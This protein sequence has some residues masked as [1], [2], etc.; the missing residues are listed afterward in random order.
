MVRKTFAAL[1]VLGLMIMIPVTSRSADT[2]NVG[3]LAVG[4]SIWW[5]GGYVTT[6]PM[7][8]APFGVSNQ[9]LD[10]CSIQGHPCFRYDL[11]TAS[12]GARLRIGF[13][14]PMRDDGFEITVRDAAGGVIG[15][16]TN[17]NKYSVELFVLNPPAATY[18][19]TVA[20]YSADYAHFRMRAKLE[21]TI[22][23]LGGTGDALPNL[24]VTRLWEFTFAA[25]LNPAN[26]LFPPD[27]VNP[28]MEAGGVRPMS[29]ALDEQL[30]YDGP[31][32]KRCLR[33][34]F[35]LANIGV[36]NFDVRFTGDQSGAPA[37]MLQCVQQRGGGTPRA[38]PAGTGSWHAT[39]GHYHYDDIIHHTI[40]RVTDRT[41]GAMEE[42]GTGLKIGYSPADQG[43]PMWH[44][45]DQAGAG[46]SA[47]AGDCTGG[48][49]ASRVGM[50]PGWGD[51]YRY[52]RPGNFVSFEGAGDGFYVVQTTADPLSVVLES[53]ED[54]NTS[55]A[56]IRVV[57]EQIDILESGLGTSP[58][59]S[60]ERFDL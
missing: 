47:S 18:H 19:I 24:R 6:D 38:L 37:D 57:G 43:M 5:N 45:F 52:Q 3:P 42:V 59:N 32:A 30:G 49:A 10:R 8:S 36:G 11:T 55:Y 33:Y 22:P 25:P 28:P 39:H 53:N 16:A 9:N 21:E 4:E 20:P 58:W 44:L 54:D 1:C 60:A 17:G 41:T 2:T 31:P 40:Y 7:W 23:T 13:D 34:S 56:Y 26:G 50:S 51:A 27:D 14:T 35:G 46:T 12:A 15:R 48:Q 29:C